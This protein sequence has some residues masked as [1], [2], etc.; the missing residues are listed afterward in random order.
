MTVDDEN[1]RLG[2][3]IRGFINELYL[4]DLRKKTMRGLEGQELRG[5][6]AG[7]NWPRGWDSFSP[8]ALG[9]HRLA[10]VATHALFIHRAAT[11]LRSRPVSLSFTA[12]I[13]PPQEA[14]DSAS[15]PTF[16]SLCF[17]SHDIRHTKYDIRILGRRGYNQFELPPK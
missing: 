15:S 8:V 5:L 4:D 1:Y 16:F 11:V 7:E 3:H 13:L 14:L 6:S 10:P 17:F 9:A 12:F 2:I